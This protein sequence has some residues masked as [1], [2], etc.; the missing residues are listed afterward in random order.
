MFPRKHRQVR[1]RWKF[2][3]GNCGEKAKTRRLDIRSLAAN[4]EQTATNILQNLTA[5][6]LNQEVSTLNAAI[7]DAAGARKELKPVFARCF[8]SDCRN[9][10]KFSNRL[11][12]L[13]HPDYRDASRAYKRMCKQ[14]R[15][16]YE[17][18][19]LLRKIEKAAV[20]PFILSKR[21]K[22]AL[23]SAVPRSRIYEHFTSLITASDAETGRASPRLTPEFP[24]E[25]FTE[26][27]VLSILRDRERRQASI[28]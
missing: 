13:N 4:A 28:L 17:E 25:L 6:C 22:H 18:R 20:N 16:E 10:R 8:D 5:N 15:A 24:I 9:A 2:C 7:S 26:E 19:E 12:R 14:K 21:R 27:E 23:V 1:S 3:S 11:R